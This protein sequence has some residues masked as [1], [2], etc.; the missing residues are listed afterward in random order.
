MPFCKGRNTS[1]ERREGQVNQTRG[2]ARTQARQCGK[3]AGKNTIERICEDRKSPV[4]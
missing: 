4:I 1:R 2:R 3:R